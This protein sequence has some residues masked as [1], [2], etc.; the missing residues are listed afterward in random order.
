MT[1]GPSL[2]LMYYDPS[3]IDEMRNFRELLAM[4][5]EP[6]MADLIEVLS[7]ECGRRGYWIQDIALRD[8]SK[9]LRGNEG[10]YEHTD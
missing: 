8:V 7:Q 1:D 10:E 9:V 4:R 3:Q 5:D 6:F 2:S